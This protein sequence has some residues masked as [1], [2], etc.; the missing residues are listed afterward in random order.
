M[1]QTGAEI[2]NQLAGRDIAIILAIGLV[3]AFLFMI[4]FALLFWRTLS[5]LG[6]QTRA[7]GR[8]A[9]AIHKRA[10]HDELQTT[11]L[12][13]VVTTNQKRTEIADQAYQ[14]IFKLSA[15]MAEYRKADTEDTGTLKLVAVEL[16]DIGRELLTISRGIETRLSGVPAERT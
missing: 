2:V 14:E 9:N 7:I 5:G 15:T 1:E 6:Q 3:F 4:I 10:V 12:K 16:R 13:D 8:I 11:I